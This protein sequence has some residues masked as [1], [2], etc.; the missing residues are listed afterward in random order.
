MIRF[1]TLCKQL[2][3]SRMLK[4]KKI[5]MTCKRSSSILSFNSEIKMEKMAHSTTAS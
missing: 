4:V 2:P 1:G 5:S 3:I